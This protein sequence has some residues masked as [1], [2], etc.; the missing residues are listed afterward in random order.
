MKALFFLLLIAC[1]GIVSGQG[2]LQFNQALVLE[3]SAQTCT[4]CWTVPAGKVWKVEQ[5][6]SNSNNVLRFYVNNKQLAYMTGYAFSIGSTSY[7]GAQWGIN[8]P[9]WLPAN[10]TMGFGNMESSANISFFVLEFNVV[11]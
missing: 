8:F 5:F 9:F 7:W 2:N 6:S 1:C 4:A 10:A 3:S 11:P